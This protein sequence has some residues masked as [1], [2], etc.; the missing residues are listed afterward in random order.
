VTRGCLR[1]TKPATP[2]KYIGEANAAVILEVAKAIGAYLE[3]SDVLG[4]LIT[5][6]RPIVEFGA[7]GI[8]IRDGEYA[9]LHSFC[10]ESAQPKHHDSVQRQLERYASDLE[11]LRTRRPINHHHF[12]VIISSR[13]PYVCAD[14]E[15]QRR[16]LTD[17]DF[18][19]YGIRSYVALPLTKTGRIDWCSRF[20]FGQMS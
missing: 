20:P 11:P 10:T 17:D 6:L 3:L 18:L 4:A 13:E 12:S 19:K 9:K 8:V 7:V 1:R 16:F 5:T 2:G 14:V 15:T